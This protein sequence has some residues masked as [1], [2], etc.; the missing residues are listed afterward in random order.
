MSDVVNF[1]FFF[2]IKTQNT[3]ATS[4]FFLNAASS[5]LVEYGTET[6]DACRAEEW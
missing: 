4:L 1:S 2:Q 6:P 5:V 3:N